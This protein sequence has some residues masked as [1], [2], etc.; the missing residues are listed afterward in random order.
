MVGACP[1]SSALPGAVPVP[2]RSSL[3]SQAPALGASGAGVDV[4]E[5][6]G[7]EGGSATHTVWIRD[8]AL[9]V[10]LVGPG[11]DADAAGAEEVLILVL[12]GLSEA[13]EDTKVA[14]EDQMHVRGAADVAERVLIVGP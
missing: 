5:V 1:S 7:R 13:F 14:L 12:E 11:E 6:E 10:H 2:A 9:E 8:L 4:G 3:C